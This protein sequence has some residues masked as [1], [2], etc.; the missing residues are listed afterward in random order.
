MAAIPESFLQQ[1]PA[2]LRSELLDEFDSVLRNYREMR[3]EPSELNGGKFCEVVYTIV[4]GY[5]DGGYPTSASKP[6]NFLDSCKKLENADP[7]ITPHSFRILIP[8]L[9]PGIYDFRNNRG[10]GH[11][12]G[13]VDPN[14]MDATIVVEM[15]KWIL[16]ELVRVYHGPSVEQAQGAVD[17]IVDRVV[18]IVWEL[19]DGRVRVLNPKLS[20][21]E[22]MLVVL[23]SFHPQAILEKEL[24]RCVEYSNPS[25][26]R[27]DILRP[28]H[29]KALID[30]DESE[31]VICLSP[32]GIR[33]VED[34]IDLQL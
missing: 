24:I 28:A 6:K 7:K 30:Y 16:A 20:M 29:R 17:R 9:L 27:K 15:T 14:R 5:V 1:I 4:K 23:Y 10:V 12:G 22:R 33:E 25:V 21:R 3:W 26:F 18:P 34:N 2:S 19:P 8:R 11:V 32:T 13:D 31:G